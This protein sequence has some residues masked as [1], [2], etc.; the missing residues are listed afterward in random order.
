[1]S[2]T[3][4]V[5]SWSAGKDSAFGLWTVLR[6]PAFEVR[7]LLTT[8][9][10]DYRRVSMSGVRE[11]LLESQAQALGLPLVKVWIPPECPNSLYEE[12]MAEAL[13]SEQLRNVR[14]IAFA[15]LYLQDVR[16][17]REAWLATVGKRGVFPL[18]A[19]DTT[20]L[21]KEMIAS[22]IRATVICVNAAVLPA[23]FAGQTY[24]E[25]FL[26]QLPT[27]VDPCGEKGEF[28]TYVWGAPI[29]QAAIPCRK[30]EVVSR[31]GFIY[32]DVIPVTDGRPGF[33]GGFAH[34]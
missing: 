32:C 5:F 34:V 27:G 25:N 6:D 4:L 28:H 26:E 18:W 1:M 33:I 29:Y 8:L 10:E 23:S 24:D 2:P 13:A 22:G 7:A 11:E 30:G 17:Y 14:H 20:T 3:P 21:A 31:D 15:D 19:R 12:R 16:T 9:T